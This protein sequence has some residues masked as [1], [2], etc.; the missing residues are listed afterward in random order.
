MLSS[1]LTEA[2]LL[3]AINKNRTVLQP[4]NE[5]NCQKNISALKRVGLTVNHENRIF[6]YS[7]GTYLRTKY[8]IVLKSRLYY[9][10]IN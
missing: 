1:I 4:I 9:L 8:Q 6:K 3:A 5:S 2:E 7:N 10:I